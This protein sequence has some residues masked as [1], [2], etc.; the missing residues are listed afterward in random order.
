MKNKISSILVILLVG[1]F[2]FSFVSSTELKLI[3]VSELKQGDVMIDKNGNEI[4]VQN[5][6]TQP[7][8]TKTI[9]EIIKNKLS[10]SSNTTVVENSVK[11]AEKQILVG[12]G[13]KRVGI[14]DAFAVYN[15]PTSE[16]T[17]S[18]SSLVFAMTIQKIKSI[19]SLG[20]WQ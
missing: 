3:K 15:N 19:I 7:Q 6:S 16:T 2:L 8:N 11:I 10:G 13:S 14:I 20:K 9:G 17:P 5:I 12:A 4:V 18:K 1:I